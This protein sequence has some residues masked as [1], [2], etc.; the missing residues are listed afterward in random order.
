MS[1]GGPGKQH[2]WS[3]DPLFLVYDCVLWTLFAATHP[4]CLSSAEMKEKSTWLLTDTSILD[5]K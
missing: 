4:I 1:L 3:L 5:V 2:R